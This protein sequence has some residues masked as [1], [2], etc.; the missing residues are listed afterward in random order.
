MM[1]DVSRASDSS[2][3]LETELFAMWKRNGARLYWR[4]SIY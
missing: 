1:F 3:S 2:P 4:R